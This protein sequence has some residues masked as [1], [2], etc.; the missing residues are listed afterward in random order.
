[1]PLVTKCLRPEDALSMLREDRNRF[2]IVVIDLH[3]PQMDD[4]LKLLDDIVALE[5]DLPVVS[6]YILSHFD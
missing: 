2:D 5:M 4:G 1:M 6:K 3:M